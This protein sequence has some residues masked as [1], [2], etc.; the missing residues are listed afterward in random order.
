MWPHW[1]SELEKTQLLWPRRKNVRE[2]STIHCHAWSGKWIPRKRK[3]YEKMDRHGEEGLR[4][5]RNDGRWGAMSGVRKTHGEPR[6]RRRSVLLHRQGAKEERRST[7]IWH[8]FWRRRIWSEW[9]L[10]NRRWQS[11][12]QTGELINIAPVRIY[13]RRCLACIYKIK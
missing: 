4:S 12:K 13:S 1:E 2:S 5:K 6:W 11:D 10:A 3:T 9:V 8:T 7:I